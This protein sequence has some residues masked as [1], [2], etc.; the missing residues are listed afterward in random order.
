MVDVLLLPV[1]KASGRD[2]GVAGISKKV[3][4]TLVR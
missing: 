3:R 1:T 2:T 4:H